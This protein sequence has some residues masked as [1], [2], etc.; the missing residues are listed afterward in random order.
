MN[1]Y[2]LLAISIF[3]IGLF[4]TQVVSAQIDPLNEI[5]FLQTGNLF[6]AENQFQISNDI[7]IREFFYGNIVYKAHKFKKCPSELTNHLNRL[8]HKRYNST[9]LSDN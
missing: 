1:F 2:P 6:T 8:I 4:S 5:D 7:T 3:S 9:L